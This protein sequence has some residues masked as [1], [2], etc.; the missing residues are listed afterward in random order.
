MK[1]NYCSKCGRR[2]IKDKQ[3][4]FCPVHLTNMT[5]VTWK[6]PKAKAFRKLKGNGD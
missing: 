2:L 3:G 4:K 6:H 5:P 1:R